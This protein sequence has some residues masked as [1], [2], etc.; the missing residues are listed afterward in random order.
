MALSPNEACVQ[1]FL[2]LGKNLHISSFSFHFGFHDQVPQNEQLTNN[3]YLFLT[4]LENGSPRCHD[5]QVLRALFLVADHWLLTITSH[6]R[7][8][9]DS[10]FIKALIPSKVPHPSLPNHLQKAPPP[11]TLDEGVG[12]EHMNFAGDTNFQFL[13]LSYIIRSL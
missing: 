9:P 13:T 1:L 10:P 8:G 6:G 7:N 3:R 4:V 2:L 11:N 5:G 12:F